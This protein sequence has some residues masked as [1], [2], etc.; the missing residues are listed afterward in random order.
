[1]NRSI[2]LVLCWLTT[3]S[4]FGQG[5]VVF[6]DDFSDNR[7]SWWEGSNEDY[8]FKV[9]NGTYVFDNYSQTT[10]TIAKNV[11]LTQDDDFVIETTIRKVSGVDNQVYGLVWGYQDADNCYTFSLSDRK[12]VV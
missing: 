2:A 9:T 7:N 6:Q 5:N 12:S 8:F 10:Y 4:L 11:G 1:M 3:A